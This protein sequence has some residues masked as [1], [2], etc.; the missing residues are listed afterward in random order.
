[1]Q[2]AGNIVVLFITLSLASL[3]WGAESTGA[4]NDKAEKPAD[5]PLGTWRGESKCLV[6]PSACHDEDS[7]YRIS[8]SGPSQSRVNLS[9]NKLVDGREVNMGSG[10]CAYDL[11]SRSLNCALPGGKSIH[12]EM[13]GRLIEGNMILQDGTL[14]RKIS[15]HKVNGN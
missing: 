10:D 1:M 14:W 7:I 6:K 15:L 12:L 4:D 11:R 5:S 13:N 8:A 9:A 3:L 2:R